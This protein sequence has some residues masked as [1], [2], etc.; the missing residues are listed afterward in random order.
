MHMVKFIGPLLRYQ[1]PVSCRV[2]CY[3]LYLSGYMWPGGSNWGFRMWP[4]P[5]SP[6]GNPP[7]AMRHPVA[8]LSPAPRRACLDRDQGLVIVPFF[9]PSVLLPYLM[10][11]NLTLSFASSSL[12][13]FTTFLGPLLLTRLQFGRTR[14][15]L[16]SCPSPWAYYYVGLASQFAPG[17]DRSTPGPEV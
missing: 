11:A 17:Q 6:S 14:G 5:L 8:I 4:Q 1:R 3:Q 13:S 2:L 16:N 10:R 7:Q 9:R 12:A 15:L